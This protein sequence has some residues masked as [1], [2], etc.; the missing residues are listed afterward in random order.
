[1]APEINPQSGAKMIAGMQVLA[2]NEVLPKGNPNLVNILVKVVIDGVPTTLASSSPS[3]GFKFKVPE[4]LLP[5]SIAGA[6]SANL[7]ATGSGN[8]SSSPVVERAVQSDGS[9]LPNWLKYDP[10]TNT[11]SASEVPKG[12]KPVE[13]KIQ[14]IRNGQVFEE[15]PPIMIDAN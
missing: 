15:S 5:E 10:D 9:P 6:S 2:G 1:M 11:F 4:A 13:I 7:A 3:V 12:A 8:T 14:S